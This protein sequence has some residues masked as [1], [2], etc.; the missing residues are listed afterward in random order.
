[1]RN[2]GSDPSAPSEHLPF[3]GRLFCRGE[4]CSPGLPET[5]EGTATHR[6][7]A[8]TLCR[9]GRPRRPGRSLGTNCRGEF[10]SPG[11][12]SGLPFR[13]TTHISLPLSGKACIMDRWKGTPSLTRRPLLKNSLPDCFSIH[14]LRGAFVRR[15]SPSAEG[16]QG[17]C[18]WIPAGSERLPAPR[19]YY[20]NS[21][22]NG[23]HHNSAFQVKKAPAG[24]R[25]FRFILLQAA[26]R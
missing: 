2:S 10:R 9:G 11:R 8:Y 15:V 25:S 17:L 24:R 19:N 13:S 26:D 1:M 14:P 4:H 12:F 21:S 7:W 6:P 23:G 22:S 3:Q 16:D 18:P 20:F 5:N